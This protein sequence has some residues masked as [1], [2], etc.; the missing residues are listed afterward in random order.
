MKK[1]RTITAVVALAFTGT[2]LVGA[3]ATA[4]DPPHQSTEAL[5]CVRPQDR[6]ECSNYYSTKV[7]KRFSGSLH[8]R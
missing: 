1:I 7:G 4:G 8:S 5:W 2:L 6:P 3:I